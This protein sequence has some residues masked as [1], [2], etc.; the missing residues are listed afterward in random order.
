METYGAQFTELGREELFV[1]IGEEVK[2]FRF[3][4][5]FGVANKKLQVSFTEESSPHQ[6]FEAVILT[7]LL[8]D[9]RTHPLAGVAPPG[10]VSRKL[11]EWLDG[12]KKI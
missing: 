7:L 12:R 9:T 6:I 4:K 5:A 1:A 11:Q 10:D 2:L 8:A 3:A